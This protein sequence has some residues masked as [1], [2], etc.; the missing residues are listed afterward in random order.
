MKFH[1]YNENYEMETVWQNFMDYHTS[2]P[3]WDNQDYANRALEPFNGKYNDRQGYVEFD[4]LEDYV[5]FVMR[6]S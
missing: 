2:W 4:T 6:W 1:V 3:R 5:M